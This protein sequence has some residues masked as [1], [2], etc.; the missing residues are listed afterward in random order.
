M[1]IGPCQYRIIVH[2]FVGKGFGKTIRSPEFYCLSGIHAT[3]KVTQ[4]F[5]VSTLNRSLVFLI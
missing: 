4:V 2:I 1:T 3:D 5:Q